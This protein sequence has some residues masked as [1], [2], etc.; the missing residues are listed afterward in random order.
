MEKSL[1][2]KWPAFS[3]RFV[4]NVLS[5]V[6]AVLALYI[7]VAPV[8]PAGLFWWRQH[9]ESSSAPVTAAR[10]HKPIPKTD[11]LIIPSIFLKEAIHEGS[12]TYAELKKGVWR[13]PS[14]S[15]PDKG[16]NTVIA[17]HRFYYSSTA[18]FYNLDKVA[19]GNPISIY[20][21]GKEY[22]YKV[23]S[24]DVVQPTDV[25]VQDPTVKPT[26]TLYTCTPLWTSKYRLVVKAELTGV[27]S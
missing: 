2:L 13:V 5:G 21:G 4:N 6:V 18:V 15:T 3:L 1:S 25:S 27:H 22:D 23:I 26:L 7:I 8:L 24:T 20:W 19:K 14:S 9:F 16:S 17:G 11:E 10:Q 12:D